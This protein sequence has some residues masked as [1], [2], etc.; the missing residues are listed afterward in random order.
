MGKKQIDS[1]EHKWLRQPGETQ[2]AFAAFQIFLDLGTTRTVTDV[3]YK[4]GKTRTQTSL[5]CSKY[6][7]RER[8]LAY[9]NYLMV[10]KA[11]KA[12]KEVEARYERF[13]KLSDQLMAF[14]ATKL[15]TSNP[16]KMTHREA[17]DFIQTAMKLAEAHKDFVA[18]P[19]AD[20]DVSKE[21]ALGFLE[22]FN[23]EQ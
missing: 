7:W 23:D 6:N 18:P 14:G 1:E 2:K 8:A 12:K 20:N 15:K 10:D 22:A 16:A 17:I 5:W 13:G 11:K 21:L 3:G 9:D 4:I 19:E